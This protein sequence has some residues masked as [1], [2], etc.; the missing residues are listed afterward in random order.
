MKFESYFTLQDDVLENKLGITDPQQLKQAEA[1]I[2]AVRASE[3]FQNPPDGKMDYAYLK[4]IHRQLFSDLYD[5]AGET[6]K[7][8]MAKGDSAFCYIAFI[9]D[10]QK[11]IFREL[12]RN[13]H[14]E[15]DKTE[16]VFRLTRLAADLNA[17]HPFR[18]GNGR[19][20]RLFLTLLA[21]R[22]GYD[23]SYD[24]IEAEQMMTADIQAFR[25]DFALLE[26]VYDA[27]LSPIEE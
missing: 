23:L 11:R 21:R 18:E 17:L 27:I 13:F 26:N 10:E 25:G 20:I 4:A 5:F 14:S 9:E 16:F 22:C 19:T 24:G 8:D 12:A 3:V 15:M 2:V 6:R 7:V 1:A